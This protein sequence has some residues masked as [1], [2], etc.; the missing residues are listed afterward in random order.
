MITDPN[1]PSAL[2]IETTN[3][4][5]ARCVFCYYP[6]VHGTMP[7]K[8]MDMD[9]FKSVLKDYI[10]MGGREISLTPTIADPLVDQLIDERLRY[11]DRSL[12]R[13]LRFY[14]NFINF[15]PK[16]MEAFRS[17]SRTKFTIG[18]S[19]TGFNREM[20]HK[21]MGVDK[22]DKVMA[23]LKELSKIVKENPN[24]SANLVLRKYE[25]DSGETGR[26]AQFCKDHGFGHKFEKVYDTWGGL[27]EE[28]IK[29]N[30]YLK[31]KIRKRLPRTKPCEVTYRKPLITVD[32]DYKVCECRDVFGE[33]VIGNV[34]ETPFSELWFG[35]EIKKLRQRFYRQDTLPEICKKCEMYKPYDK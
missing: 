23:N 8:Y 2:Y 35:S 10:Q 16:V 27:M 28:D 12:I 9:L 30:P 6:K 1:L 17:M 18:I 4:C 14:S 13:K 32:G 5:N 21:L 26:M 33:L 20:Y 31:G 34:K 7:V 3:L 15:R 11:I 19:M 22:Y 25:G 24:V 29:N